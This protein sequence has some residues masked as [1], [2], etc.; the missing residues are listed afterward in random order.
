MYAVINTMTSVPGDSIGT[1]LSQHR[2]ARAARASDSIIQRR[3]R[4]ANGDNSYLPT[5]IV[6]LTR[7][8]VG[9]HIGNEEWAPLHVS[10][11]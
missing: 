2:T 11:E 5:I 8:P 3:T 6:R 10:Y 1:I 9:R 7:K 4:A